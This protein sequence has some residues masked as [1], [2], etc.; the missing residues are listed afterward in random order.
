MSIRERQIADILEED[1]R[2]AR[3][4]FDLTK[5]WVQV[6]NE[7]I[8]PREDIDYQAKQL[9]ERDVGRLA[10]L[11]QDKLSALSILMADYEKADALKTILRTAD[12]ALLYNQI[13]NVIISPKT[14]SRA[15]EMNVEKLNSI[16][17]LVD[18]VVYATRNFMSKVHML[19]QMGDDRIAIFSITNSQ[20]IVNVLV[21]Y[22]VIQGQ[23][24]TGSITPITPFIIESVGQTV[25]SELNENE[26][27]LVADSIMLSKQFP[28]LYD[29]YVK[30]IA[31]E[32]QD[33][34]R[35]LFPNEKKRLAVEIFGDTLP[36]FLSEDLA[37]ELK[38]QQEEQQQAEQG[39]NPPADA[40]AGAV[41]DQLEDIRKRYKASLNSIS[42]ELNSIKRQYKASSKSNDTLQED[43][44]Y[45]INEYSTLQEKLSVYTGEAIDPPE[46]E[47]ELVERYQGLFQN[48]R[49]TP[50]DRRLFVSALNDF[51]EEFMEDVRR[52]VEFQINE[53]IDQIPSGY[54]GFGHPPQPY[55]YFMYA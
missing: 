38:R 11:L 18:D 24:N 7:T 47:A 34:G 49:E 45:L 33:I 26:K 8:A 36:S 27:L 53:E 6:S 21:F 1:N 28:G 48:P 25:H 55:H 42:D 31:Q 4:V 9:V 2:I 50:E 12:V 46:Q 20:R 13:A 40:D 41:A 23:L 22:R 32:E 16:S 5:K 39:R 10:V 51:I 54:Q 3:R 43:L 14:T 35:S 52:L 30:A 44:T 29:K 17:D 15:K 19:S 37:D